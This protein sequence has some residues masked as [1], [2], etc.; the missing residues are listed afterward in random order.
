MMNKKRI[1]ILILLFLIGI[2]P[3]AFTQE[4]WV[5]PMDDL[6]YR[7]TEEIFLYRGFVPPF[8]ETPLIA[9]DLRERIKSLIDRSES[10]EIVG[11]AG[12]LLS[13]IHLP[14]AHISPILELG[15]GLGVNSETDRKHR[16]NSKAGIDHRFLD[17]LS[18]YELER[19]V[20]FL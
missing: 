10:G 1:F 18:L 17:Y 8:E 5:I 3:I 20:I 15:L 2:S 12:A 19:K 9:D 16:I 14:F 11:R 7:R 13:E 6:L 4:S